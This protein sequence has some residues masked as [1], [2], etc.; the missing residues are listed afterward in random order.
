[1]YTYTYM[2]ALVVLHKELMKKRIVA[3]VGFP[4]FVYGFI[5]VDS[6]VLCVFPLRHY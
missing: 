6:F 3:C 2:Y 4:F 5:T 1:M